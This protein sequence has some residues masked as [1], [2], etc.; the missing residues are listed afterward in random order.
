[1]KPAISLA[2][3]LLATVAPLDSSV[4][5]GPDP[6]S[7][8]DSTI[9]T[10]EDRERLAV[11]RED[12]AALEGLWSEQLIV[13]NPQNTI[14]PDRATVVALVRQGRIRYSRFERRIE[15][16]RFYDDLVVVMGSETIVRRGAQDSVPTPI[17]RRFSH[18]WR[19]V[20]GEWR[21]I[22]RH[23]NVIPPG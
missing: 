23:A 5:Q 2:V 18:V 4:A 9:R 12:V 1:V 16:I 10:L 7:G 14:S 8:L 11:L 22:A 21:L 15:A 17:E 19:R 3:A 13:N 6:R 20:G